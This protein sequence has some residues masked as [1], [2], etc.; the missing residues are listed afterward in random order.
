[1]EGDPQVQGTLIFRIGTSV[2]QPLPSGPPGCSSCSVGSV[3]VSLDKVLQVLELGPVTPSGLKDA[4]PLLCNVTREQLRARGVPRAA[5]SVSVSILQET[6]T[7]KADPSVAS[8]FLRQADFL[9]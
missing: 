3:R 5:A 7:W 9:C 8:G 6:D 2:V 4:K 1:M